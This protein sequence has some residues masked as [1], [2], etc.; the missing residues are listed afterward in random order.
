MKKFLYQ[1]KY[2][3]LGILV[4]L[5][6]FEG[7]PLILN[8][9]FGKYFHSSNKLI[10]NVTLSLAEVFILL[11]LFLIFRKKIIKD[12]KNF[13]KDYKKNLNI[14]FK[15]YCI[16]FL[17]MAASNLILNLIFGGIAT[18]EAVN[19]E[20]LKNYPLYSIIAMVFIGPLVEEIVFRL[21]FKKAF[22]KCLPYAIFSAVLFGSL[23]VYTAYE[24]MSIAEILKNWSQILYVVPY[25]ALGFSFAKTFYETDNIFTSM[26]IHVLHNAFT[27]F[28]IFCSV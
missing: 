21:G 2:F 28:L 9:F 20:Y 12:F 15:Y 11:I 13:K 18:N 10:S 4:F 1:L 6:Y 25:G 16:G 23:H 7:L 17:V 27:I 26:T 14:G 19:R 22:K 3:G 5:I 24:G 8:Y